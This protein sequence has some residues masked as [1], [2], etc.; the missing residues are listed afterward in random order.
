MVLF[1]D[2]RGIHVKEISLT[3][4]QV[5]LVDDE[6]FKWLNQYKWY[7]NWCNSTE[8]FY[9]IRMDSSR[10]AIRMARLIMNCPRNKLV[11]HKNHNTL[12]NQ[13]HNL[14]IC[15]QNE[16]LQNARNYINSSSKY[17]GVSWCKGNKKWR[18]R[19]E[20]RDIFDQ[21]YGKHLGYFK[22][23]IDAAKAYNEAAIRYFGEFACLNFSTA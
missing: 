12:D 2:V 1:N 22:D 9:A 19:I 3:Q 14:R 20:L 6:D 18:A 17:K 16:N 11:D 5:A 13:K 8:S 10:K 21:R 7:A 15:T 23:E 4:E